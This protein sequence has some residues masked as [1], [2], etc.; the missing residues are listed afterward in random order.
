MY[1]LLL[2][3]EGRE[4]FKGPS[5]QVVHIKVGMRKKKNKTTNKGTLI[6]MKLGVS[7]NYSR[8]SFT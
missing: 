1:T 8:G 3:C 6:A 2:P 4:V 7:A 5:P